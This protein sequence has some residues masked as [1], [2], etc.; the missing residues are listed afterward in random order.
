MSYGFKGFYGYCLPKGGQK[1]HTSH[2]Y[3]H[4]G[5]WGKSWGY[6]KDFFSKGCSYEKDSYYG[7]GWGKD[8]GKSWGYSKDSCNIKC[9]GG[10]DFGYGKGWS[11]GKGWDCG[12]G[13][14]IKGSWCWDTK[15]GWYFEPQ[16]KVPSDKNDIVYGTDKDDDI[17]TGKGNDIIIAKKGNDILDGESGHDIMIGG[18][19]DDTYYVDNQC[20]VVIE[21]ANEGNDTILS[22]VNIAAPSNVENISLLTDNNLSAIGNKLNNVLHGNDGHNFLK[23]LEGND[24]LYGHAGNDI[25][26]GGKGNDFLNGGAGCDILNGGEGCDTYVFARGFDNDVIYDCDTNP[27]HKDILQFNGDITASDLC[28]ERVG[29]DLLINIASQAED[30]GKTSEDSVTINNWFKGSQFQIEE[31]VFTDSNVTWNAKQ[32]ADAVNCYS[33]ADTGLSNSI[34]EQI[35]IQSQICC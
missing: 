26:V 35:Q 4:K 24:N 14:Q 19:G 28:F 8:F 22:S 11:Y 5:G 31:F 15:K 33:C 13:K 23:S 1:W 25:L 16:S 12:Y 27:E 10:K 32:I 30:G 6:S 7:K 21:K 18:K 2:S 9:W 20:D 3:G 29:N 17:S 34:Q